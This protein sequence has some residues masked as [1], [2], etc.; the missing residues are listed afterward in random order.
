MEILSEAPRPFRWDLA[1]RYRLGAQLE[2]PIAP[3]YEGFLD[4][5]FRASARVIALCGD[6]DLYFIGR[7]L[8][9]MFD[10]LT[11]VTCHKPI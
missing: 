11:G 9:S 1:R 5:L 7:S 3:S 8:E 10:L 6:S 2:G 4:D